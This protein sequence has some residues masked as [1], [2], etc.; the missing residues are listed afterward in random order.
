M[1]TE[2]SFGRSGQESKKDNGPLDRMVLVEV[3][4]EVIGS[5]INL[6]GRA[7]SNCAQTTLR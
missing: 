5:R 2:S 6:E 1:E 4:R 7:D 3:S